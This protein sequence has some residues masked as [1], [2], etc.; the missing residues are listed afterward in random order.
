MSLQLWFYEIGYHLGM[1]LELCNP[2]RSHVAPETG[3]SFIRDDQTLVVLPVLLKRL[4][5]PSV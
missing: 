5:Q 4:I 1:H 2:R 3:V